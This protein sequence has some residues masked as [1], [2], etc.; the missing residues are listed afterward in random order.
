VE[1]EEL[2]GLEV[3]DSFDAQ[4]L[5][6]IFATRFSSLILTFKMFPTDEF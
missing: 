6:D 3:V 4:G 5:D 1:E 2:E